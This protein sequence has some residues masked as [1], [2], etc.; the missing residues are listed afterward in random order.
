MASEPIRQYFEKKEGEGYVDLYSDYKGNYHGYVLY[1][2]NKN[3]KRI[4]VVLRCGSNITRE[5]GNFDINNIS[6]LHLL[7][8][9]A[10]L[11]HKTRSKNIGYL[12][13][14]ISD[15]SELIKNIE[16]VFD[17][18]EEKECLDEFLKN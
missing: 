17:K 7:D 5:I 14:P 1:V 16:K 8:L 2:K 4:A 3:A 12:L 11:P 10:E 6:W 15:K 18:T 9:F 13:G